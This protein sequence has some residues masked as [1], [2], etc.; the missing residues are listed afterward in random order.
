M[1]RMGQISRIAIQL[2]HE[3]GGLRP[4]RVPEGGLVQTSVSDMFSSLGPLSTLADGCLSNLELGVYE[5]SEPLMLYSELE[6]DGSHL[7]VQRVVLV[8]CAE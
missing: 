3:D 8:V 7:S 6:D 1:S 2:F 4:E 5:F